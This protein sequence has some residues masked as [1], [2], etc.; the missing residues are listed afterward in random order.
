[1]RTMP[2]SSLYCLLAVHHHSQVYRSQHNQDGNREGDGCFQGFNRSASSQEM[3][4]YLLIK[5]L[6]GR[7]GSWNA[8]PLDLD[9]AGD[10]LHDLGN[11]LTQDLVRPICDQDDDCDDHSNFGRLNSICIV[12][13]THSS[14]LLSAHL[15]LTLKPFQP[16]LLPNDLSQEYR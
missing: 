11:L 9:S 7:A 3:H 15:C 14:H 16:A 2:G 10:I 13:K 12:K 8:L 5:R 4:I 1:M 6:N